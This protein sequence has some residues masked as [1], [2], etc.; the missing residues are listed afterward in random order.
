MSKF[1][2][3]NAFRQASEQ[4]KNKSFLDKHGTILGGGVLAFGMILV[5]TQYAGNTNFSADVTDEE[6]TTQEE[7]TTENTEQT[8]TSTTESE[9][10]TTAEAE[11]GKDETNVTE[12]V[13]ETSTEEESEKSEVEVEDTETITE[14][15]PESE[16][17]ILTENTEVQTVTNTAPVVENTAPET[18]D[19][20]NVVPV[21]TA[22]PEEEIVYTEP[23]QAKIISAPSISNAKIQEIKKGIITT[24][25]A[26]YTLP[27]GYVMNEASFAPEKTEAT[28]QYN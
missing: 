8:E 22:L 17:I 21:P 10:I 20:V 18:V 28:N 26:N 12:E 5:G 2:T 23:S 3:N 13:A 7:V 4:Q 27:N 11:D 15:N 9:E 16:E 14:K 19:A 1:N 25:N 24:S 6:E